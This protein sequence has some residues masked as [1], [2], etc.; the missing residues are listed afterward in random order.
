M[1]ES[2]EELKSFLRVKEE[3][4]K[5]DLK[6]N[7]KNTKIMASGPI[8]SREIEGEKLE[9]V[10]DFILVGSKITTN[11]ACSQKIKRHLLLGRKAMMDLDSALKS[12]DFTL[13]TKACIVKAIVFTV[14]M[15]ICQ[16]WTIKKAEYQRTDAFKLWC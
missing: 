5:A 10:T 15:Y 14:L 9:E 8:I 12:R 1:V 11:G 16:S 7:I 4:E 2:E 13:L 3:S 6:L